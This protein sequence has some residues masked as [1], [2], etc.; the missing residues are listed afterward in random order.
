MPNQHPPDLP[1]ALPHGTSISPTQTLHARECHLIDRFDPAS[2]YPTIPQEGDRQCK[3]VG[4]Q[5]T[6]AGL[7]WYQFPMC[8]ESSHN[9]EKFSYIGKQYFSLTEPLYGSKNKWIISWHI[10]TLNEESDLAFPRLHSLTHCILVHCSRS[11]GFSIS[12]WSHIRRTRS[13]DMWLSIIHARVMFWSLSTLAIGTPNAN[14]NFASRRNTRRP[15]GESQEWGSTER[16]RTS[17]R[18]L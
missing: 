15:L 1:S 14:R 2:G 12:N 8:Q 3:W 4:V 10:L 18:P 6:W 5:I 17:I 9:A 11:I 7:S 13:T 16:R